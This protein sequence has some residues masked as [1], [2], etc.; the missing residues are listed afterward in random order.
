[1]S[2]YAIAMDTRALLNASHGIAA[3]ARDAAGNAATSPTVPVTVN[4]PARLIITGPTSGQTIAGTTLNVTYT[5]ARDLTD[6]NH[7]HFQLDANI[8]V[9]DL[10][11]DGSYQMANVGVGQH[12]LYGWLVRADHSKIQGTDAAPI[13]FTMSGPDTTPPQV[14][15]TAPLAGATVAGLVQGSANARDD[16]GIASV[17]FLIDGSNLG[18]ED[19]AAPYAAASDT[20]ALPSG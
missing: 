15:L 9:M 11:F 20:S 1:T 6:D 3:V 18:A 16:V 8:E 14:T 5:T 13:G 17:H 19:T 7:V 10:N 4:N 2:P 12:V